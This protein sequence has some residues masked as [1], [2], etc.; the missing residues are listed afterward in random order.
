[1][2]DAGL[3]SL[4]TP[5]AALVCLD[6]V[7]ATAS[8]TTPVEPAPDAAPLMSLVGPPSQQM[9]F[10]LAE[11]GGSGAAQDADAV[12]RLVA[13]LQSAYSSIF[14]TLDATLD[15]MVATMRR[16]P[17]TYVAHLVTGV[18]GYVWEQVKG[19]LEFVVRSG[20]AVLTSAVCLLESAGETLADYA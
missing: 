7:T 4:A 14:G 5:D 19:L 12:S 13:G 8:T 3:L 1:M 9:L 20:E 17:T 15:A 6:A 16:D 2:T 18:V 11:P 10:T